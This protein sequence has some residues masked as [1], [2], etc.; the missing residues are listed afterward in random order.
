[1][2]SFNLAGNPEYAA[3]LKQLRQR[4]DALFESYAAVDD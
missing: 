1:M 4:T 3:Q 2:S